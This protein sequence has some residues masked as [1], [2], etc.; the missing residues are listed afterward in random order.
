MGILVRYIFRGTLLNCFYL[1]SISASMIWLIQGIKYFKI[2]VNHPISILS[3][4]NMT[5]LLVPG[6]LVYVIPFTFCLG[7]AFFYKQFDDTNEMK[8]LP[9]LGMHQFYKPLFL[10]GC[11]ITTLQVFFQFM[12]PPS[13][14]SFFEKETEIR[15]K[16]SLKIFK[17]RQFNSH[18]EAMIFFH[19]LK[20][21]AIYDVFLSFKNTFISAKS[22]SLIYDNAKGYELI[23]KNGV[24][25]DDADQQKIRMSFDYMHYT[26]GHIIPQATHARKLMSLTFKE[27]YE[28]NSDASKFEIVSRYLR[29]L[30]P[31]LNSL[32][33]YFFIFYLRASYRFLLAGFG[34]GVVNALFI[35]LGKWLVYFI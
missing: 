1:I 33:L 17:P 34:S 24:T 26:L 12:T 18:G 11:V 19:H 35:V 6:I 27:L 30:L 28:E 7:A 31:F 5:L 22:A 29:F 23:V 15:K 9:M 16:I 8:I 14:K 2:L 21:D 10:C 20:G 13:L 25:I 3:L 32:V 4:I